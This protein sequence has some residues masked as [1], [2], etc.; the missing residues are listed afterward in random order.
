MQ[1]TP[2]SSS[3]IR[4]LT[5]R[6]NFSWTFIGMVV[7]GACQWGVLVLLAKIGTPEMV[8]Q[9]TLG[10]AV[11]APIAMLTD[12]NL[13]QVQATDATHQYSFGDYLGL[14]WITVGLSLLLIAIVAPLTGY[15]T[16]TIA[17]ILLVG[18]AKAIESLSGIFY[19]LFQQRERMD[20][21][22]ISMMI[23]GPLFLILLG[24]GVYLTGSLIWGVAGIVAA[25]CI[26]LILYDLPNGS[27][28]LRATQPRT[29]EGSIVTCQGS[30]LPSLKPRWHSKTLGKLA[31]LSLPLGFSMMLVS[32]NVNLPSYIIERYLGT[33]ELGIFAAMA[34]LM[35]I[36][37]RIVIALGESATSR[38]AQ[39]YA[40][41]NAAA[42]RVL[43]LRLVG[44]GALLGS[45]AVL[46]TVLGGRELLTLLYQPEYAMYTPI[47]FWLAIAAGIRYMANFLGYGITA[48]RYF[49]IQLPLFGLVTLTLAIGCLMWLP[50]FG[51]IGAAMALLLAAIVQAVVSSGVVA[52]ALFKLHS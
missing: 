42:F 28:L 6:R 11:T 18:L 43:L 40:Q 7:Y 1:Q 39:H 10:F 9:L 37:S 45:L 14:R 35:E 33:R 21:I 31:W 26:G 50:K 16:D 30:A 27:R 24:V 36:G 46:G 3:P 17:V 51:L 41:G 52:H 15:S 47:L 48:A 32:I 22:A 20:R 4:A 13:Q 49:R 19:G 12:L 29:S 34:Y 23:K 38:L 8:G 25:W 2:S 44:I 5:L